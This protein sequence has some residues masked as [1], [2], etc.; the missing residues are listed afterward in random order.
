[1]NYLTFKT[2]FKK[3]S[4]FLLL[5]IFVPVIA[6]LWVMFSVGKMNGVSFGYLSRDAIQTLWHEPNAE[7][8]FYIGLL[9]NIGVIF[10]CFT[11]AILFFSVKL[12]KYY[13]KP[14]KVTRFFFYSGILSVFFLVDDLFLMHDVIIPY[15][16]HISEKFL[17]LF[18]GICVLALLYLFREIIEESDYLLF[19]IAFISMAG[20]VFTDVIL[21]LGFTLKEIYLFEDGLKFI[22]IISWFVYF[23]RTCYNHLKTR[24]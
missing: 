23:A 15:F 11:A 6:L 8:E 24:G 20:S 10:W 12:A 18:Y 19:L 16:L 3:D 13:G 9:S 22:G 5:K 7:V 17:Y 1:M 2:L 4:I 21:T 14:K